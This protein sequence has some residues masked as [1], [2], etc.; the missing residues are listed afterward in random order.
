MP[1]YITG[2]ASRSASSSRYP[3]W[4]IKFCM[5]LHHV[6]WVRS[7]GVTQVPWSRGHCLAWDAT[8]PDT[9][10]VSRTGQQTRADSAAATAE[11][12]KSQIR[13]LHNRCH[14]YCDRDIGNL[15]GAS[16]PFVYHGNRPPTGNC[17]PR[18]TFNSVSTLR[19][20]FGAGT[21]LAVTEI[22]TDGNYFFFP[23]H[24]KTRLQ[25]CRNL[26]SRGGVARGGE[27]KAVHLEIRPYSKPL[28]PPLTRHSE[29]RRV[30]IFSVPVKSLPSSYNWWRLITDTGAH[31]L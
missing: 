18:T 17:G 11:A 26:K 24:S 20:H 3:C 27:G 1:V 29:W 10:S 30:G 9:C 23:N 2:C 25:Q 8:C 31:E 6:T 12:M 22:W 21:Q 19:G 15:A 28:D 7:D 13:W 4:S 16:R 14:V 5:G